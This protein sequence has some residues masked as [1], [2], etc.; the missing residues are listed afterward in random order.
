MR[1]V[2]KICAFSKALTTGCYEGTRRPLEPLGRKEDEIIWT[3][4]WGAI[5]ASVGSLLCGRFTKQKKPVSATVLGV[6]CTTLIIIGSNALPDRIEPL[7]RFLRPESAI[8]GAWIEI[9]HDPVKIK[10]ATVMIKFNPSSAA[11][12][13]NG[14]TYVVS[15]QDNKPIVFKRYFS[16]TS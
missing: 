10:Y 4:F 15:D 14:R 5:A 2:F 12:E 16:R 7:H 6:L 3:T 13:L 9:I 1:L 8:E 11:F